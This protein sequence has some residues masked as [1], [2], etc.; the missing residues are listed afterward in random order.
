[1]T[2]SE[3]S[4]WQGLGQGVESVFFCLTFVLMSYTAYMCHQ[5]ENVKKKLDSVLKSITNPMCSKYG[6]LCPCSGTNDCL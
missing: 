3:S 5:M 6:I 4:N 2:L 1:M